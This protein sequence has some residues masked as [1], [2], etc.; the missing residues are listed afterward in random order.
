MAPTGRRPSSAFQTDDAGA[1][2]CTAA[3]S[4]RSS[5]PGPGRSTPGRRRSSATSSARW[6]SACRRSRRSSGG[7]VRSAEGA[8]LRGRAVASGL[9]AEAPDAVAACVLGWPPSRCAPRRARRSTAVVP[10][11]GGR[12]VRSCRCRARDYIRFRLADAIRR[13][14]PSHRARRCAELPLVVQTSRDHWLLDTGC[15]EREF[16]RA[17]AA[18]VGRVCR[19]EERARAE[20]HVRAALRRALSSC[21]VPRAGRQGRHHRRR[22]HRA[23]RGARSPCPTRS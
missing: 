10:R 4:A 13:R 5:T 3:G 15:A 23:A 17:P 20:R 18:G 22:R 12:A 6:C 1:P 8:R 16:A 7:G 19:H 11:R 9:P 14:R 2:N 21:R